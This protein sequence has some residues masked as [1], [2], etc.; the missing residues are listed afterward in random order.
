MAKI[1]AILS[2]HSIFGIECNPR[3]KP[4]QHRKS[5]PS[6]TK[7]TI[8]D[9]AVVHCIRSFFSVS[10]YKKML[11]PSTRKNKKYQ[12]V[13]DDQIIHFGQKGSQ[14]YVE[15]ASKEKREQYLKRHRVNED[16]T[17]PNPG[18]ASRYILWGDSRDIKKNL[19][20]FLNSVA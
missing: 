5:S 4:P 14:T 8:W 10:L 12:L 16:W 3:R 15:G 20:Q 7:V 11:K 17:R 2:M 18:S 6:R 1:T 19:R 13:L 9:R